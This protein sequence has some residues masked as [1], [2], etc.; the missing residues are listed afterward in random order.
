MNAKPKAS[1]KST[2]DV[3]KSV[4]FTPDEAALTER[5]A[6][7]DERSFSAWARRH[8]VQAAKKELRGA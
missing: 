4:L 7:R 6:A 3:T 5:A 1:T 8:L 2:H